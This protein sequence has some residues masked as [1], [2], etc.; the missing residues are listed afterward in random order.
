MTILFYT[1]RPVV[2]FLFFKIWTG[3]SNCDLSDE[4]IYPVRA[5]LASLKNMSSERF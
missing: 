3:V 4:T 2:S 1:P 5:N